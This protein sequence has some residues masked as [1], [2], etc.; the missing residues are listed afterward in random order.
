MTRAEIISAIKEAWV[1]ELMDVKDIRED[2]ADSYAAWVQGVVQSAAADLQAQPAAAQQG[3]G[4][5]AEVGQGGAGAPAPAPAQ[6][7]GMAAAGA[8]GGMM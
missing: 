2:V 6:Q 1:R 5:S 8:G 4:Q 7:G 3:G